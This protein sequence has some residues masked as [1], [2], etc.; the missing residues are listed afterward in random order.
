MLE[1]S[2]VHVIQIAPLE[3]RVLVCRVALRYFEL[4]ASILT[5]NA[6]MLM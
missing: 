2:S 3:G 5:Y 1:R 6:N 4:N